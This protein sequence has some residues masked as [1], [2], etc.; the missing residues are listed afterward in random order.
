[1]FQLEE[2]GSDTFLYASVVKL[3][4]HDQMVLG[5]DEVVEMIAIRNGNREDCRCRLV[6]MIDNEVNFN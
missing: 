3:V 6:V 5:P 4:N 1:M 2:V